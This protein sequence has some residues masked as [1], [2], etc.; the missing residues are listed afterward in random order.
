MVLE[1]NHEAEPVA[2]HAVDPGRW[3]VSLVTL[4]DRLASAEF[5]AELVRT[6]P[7]VVTR[8]LVTRGRS[9][10]PS[11]IDPII[12]R[13]RTDPEFLKAVA[14]LGLALSLPE[15]Q[16]VLESL[17]A[18]ARRAQYHDAQPE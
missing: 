16:K 1:A 4:L 15:R 5:V 14:H 11:P 12:E 13:L 18:L 6:P 9:E 3:Y 10:P 8:G 17:E 7:R 2:A